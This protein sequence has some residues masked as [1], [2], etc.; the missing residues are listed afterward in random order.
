MTTNLAMEEL[1]PSWLAK[2]L[3]EMP[4]QLKQFGEFAILLSPVHLRSGLE[5]RAAA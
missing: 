5:D 3:G 4:R 2:C 1:M